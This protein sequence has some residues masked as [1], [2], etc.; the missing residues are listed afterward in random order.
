MAAW[1]EVLGYFEQFDEA[2]QQEKDV[3]AVFGIAH[4]EGRSD[5]GKG[6]EP[7]QVHGS[8]RD[9]AKLNRYEGECRDGENEE[10]CDPPGEH[11]DCHTQQ[12]TS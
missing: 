9:G 5:H 11:P 7:L 12:V 3:K 2:D 6:R 4:T 1:K 10:P 8:S